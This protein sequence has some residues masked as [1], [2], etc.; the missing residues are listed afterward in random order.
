MYDRDQYLK[1]KES[2]FRYM[3]GNEEKLV[4]DREPY[5]KAIQRIR[6][7]DTDIIQKSINSF[8]EYQTQEGRTLYH[9]YQLKS[10]VYKSLYNRTKLCKEIIRDYDREVIL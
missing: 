10:I 7:L 6:D 3:A 5:Q 4:S 8:I 9:F 2:I 1:E